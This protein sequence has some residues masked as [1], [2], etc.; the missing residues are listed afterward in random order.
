MVVI[1][2]GN[3]FTKILN[4]S[5]VCCNHGSAEPKR[6]CHSIQQDTHLD[7]I[8][9]ISIMGNIIMLLVSNNIF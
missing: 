9:L 1:K 4:S 2:V 3:I 6:T 8:P 7:E 5:P